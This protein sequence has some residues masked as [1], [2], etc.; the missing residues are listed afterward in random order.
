V[1]I[2]IA[3]PGGVARVEQCGE[4]LSVAYAGRVGAQAARLVSLRIRDDNLLPEGVALVSRV[5]GATWIKGPVPQTCISE[6]NPY[7][8][9]WPQAIVVGPEALDWWRP[10]CLGQALSGRL[11]RVF[12]DANEA[13]SW[14]LARA[15]AALAQQRWDRLPP[16]EAGCTERRLF[17]A[18]FRQQSHRASG[19]SR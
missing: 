17:S 9:A 13:A 4:L 11:R 14:A 15:R 7:V 2:E 3:I 5:D 18:A 1:V 12:T 19:P 8:M 16:E 6:G 10:Y